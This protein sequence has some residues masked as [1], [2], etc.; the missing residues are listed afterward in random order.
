MAARPP[1]GDDS[2]PDV[3]E[4]GIA[5]VAARL[6]DANVSFPATSEDVLSAVDDTAIPY[7][8]SGNTFEL[9]EALE[10]VPYD[11]FEKRADLLN[12]L[13]PIFE[14]R[15]AEGSGSVVGRLRKLLP[16]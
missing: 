5:T 6:D 16:F 7:D 9:A 14:E 11:R 13:H 4:F 12:A 2:S 8:A 10:R 1:Q 15:R 3:I